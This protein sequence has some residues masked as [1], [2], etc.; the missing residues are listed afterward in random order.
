MTDEEKLEE[1]RKE[2]S[3]TWGRQVR[4]QRICLEKKATTIQEQIECA[5]EALA[6]YHGGSWGEGLVDDCK[7]REMRL[8]EAF[9]GELP[10]DF[11]E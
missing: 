6:T 8:M 2:M 10:E 7:I 9:G 4:W 1:L 5:R 3:K 11:G